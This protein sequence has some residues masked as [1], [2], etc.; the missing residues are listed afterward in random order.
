MEKRLYKFCQ[1]N[2]KTKRSGSIAY[3]AMAKQ[4]FKQFNFGSVSANKLYFTEQDTDQ[5]LTT[6]KQKT[7]LDLFKE[8]YPEKL[9]RVERS[10]VDV[11]EKH[12]VINIRSEYV[13]LNSLNSININQQ[14]HEVIAGHS[15]GTYIAVDDVRSIEHDQLILVENLIVMGFLNEL[16]IPTELKNALWIYRGDVKVESTTGTAYKFFREFQG[17]I[18]TL[19]FSD[20]DPAG[21]LIAISSGA[22]EWMTPITPFEKTL[23]KGI[24][25]DFYKQSNACKAL[26]KNEYLPRKC[27]QAFESML[28]SKATIK[29]EHMVSHQLQLGCFSLK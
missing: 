16:I 20:F 14:K 27:K 24:D 21:I 11:S 18:K 8:K 22:D 23:P 28:Q 6:I 7:G 4:L 17:K 19:C 15:L 5:L 12:N 25:N 3:N 9:N 1:N 2:F 26:S 29:Q 10:Q 13:L